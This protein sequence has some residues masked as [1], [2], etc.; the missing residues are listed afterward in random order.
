[1]FLSPWF[2]SEA[3]AAS[4]AELLTHWKPGVRS[5]LQLVCGRVGSLGDSSPCTR[6]NP[7]LPHL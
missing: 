5:G 7:K 4:P 1:M 6:K 3:P 2:P